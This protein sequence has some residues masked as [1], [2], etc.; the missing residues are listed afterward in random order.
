[1]SIAR[2]LVTRPRLLL[3]DEPFAALDEMTRE[4]LGWDLLALRAAQG[5]AVLFVT[6]SVAEAVVLADRVVVLAARPGRAVAELRID[7]AAPRDAAYRG[8]AAYAAQCQAVSAALR[9]TLAGAPLAP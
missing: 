1:M 7:A 8:S 4:Q 9:R 5:F 3:L 2:A 6:H